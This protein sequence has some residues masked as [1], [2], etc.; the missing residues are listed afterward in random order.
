MKNEA[1]NHENEARAMFRTGLE[2]LAAA[3]RSGMTSYE[4]AAEID[5]THLG[6][7]RLLKNAARHGL[8]IRRRATR[9]VRAVPTWI[10]HENGCRWLRGEV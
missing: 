1:T 2:T 9:D 8:A 3:P 7:L 4:L 6:A 5:M 10:I